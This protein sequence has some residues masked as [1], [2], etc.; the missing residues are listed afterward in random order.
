MMI[1]DENKK[2]LARMMKSRGVYIAL[3]V[4]VLAAGFVSYSVSRVSRIPQ[5]TGTLKTTQPSTYVHIN[6]RVLPGD[7]TTF[8]AEITREPQTESTSAAPETEAVFED[9]ADPVEDTSEAPRELSF[10]LPVNTKT[11]KDFSMGIPVFSATMNDYRTHNGVDFTA[12]AGAPV[13]AIAQGKVTRVANDSLFGNTV[14][15]DHGGGVVSTV[16]GLADEGLIRE[17]AD[18]SGETVLGVVGEI[19]VEAADGSHIHLEIRVDGVLQDPLAVMGF[20]A[21]LE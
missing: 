1:N 18:V 19:P 21:D 4:C 17:G 5:E 16:S 7:I 13:C 12:D 8:P 9:A 11:G 14:T 15:V 10:S 20:S 3:A 2:S 6:E